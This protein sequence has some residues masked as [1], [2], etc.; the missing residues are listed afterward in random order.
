MYTGK[1]SRDTMGDMM[2]DDIPHT[3]D[4]T[5]R[6][7]HPRAKECLITSLVS[8]APFVC[9]VV[10]IFSGDYTELPFYF[11]GYGTVVV[12]LCCISLCVAQPLGILLGI[13]SLVQIRK[14]SSYCGKGYAIA[15]ITISFLQVA[16]IA[17]LYWKG[18]LGVWYCYLLTI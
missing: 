11:V 7:S 17:C 6:K 10:L 9:G 15:G 2:P 14:D 12:A 16:V 3:D 4:K 1:L 18:S 5:K 8:V 13:D